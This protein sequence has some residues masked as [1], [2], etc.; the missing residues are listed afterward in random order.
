MIAVSLSSEIDL[1]DVILESLSLVGFIFIL[2]MAFYANKK[3][4]IFRSKG[5]PI[6]IIGIVLGIIAAGMDLLGEFVW[7]DTGYDIYKMVMSI[8]YIF[9]LVV[10]SIAIFLV[11]RFTRFMMGEKN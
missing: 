3:N 8:L 4:P 5:F 10:F 6:L 7:F 1:L 11:F 9:S 2:I